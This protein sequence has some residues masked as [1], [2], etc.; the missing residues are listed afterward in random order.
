M[1]DEEVLIDAAGLL[2]ACVKACFHIGESYNFERTGLFK[3]PFSVTKFENIIHLHP[4]RH[5]LQPTGRGL[6]TCN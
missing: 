3:L 2:W 1:K 5:P 4:S 6:N